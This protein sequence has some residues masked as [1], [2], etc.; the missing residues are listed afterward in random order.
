MEPV[1]Q[2]LVRGPEL[3]PSADLDR[4]HGDVDGVDEIRIEELPDGG[5]AASDP[6]VLPVSGV[7]GLPQRLRRRRIEEVEGGIGQGE[8]RS[9]MMGEDE[10]GGVERRSVPPPPLPVEVLPRATLRPELV[11]AHD[12]GADVPRE[13]ARE[14]VVQPSGSTGLGSVRP[15]CGGEGPGG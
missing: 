1:E 6:Y 10:D 5:D 13:V 2:V 12:L 11:A 3:L 8:A 4:R 9:V 14:V 15:A 7:L